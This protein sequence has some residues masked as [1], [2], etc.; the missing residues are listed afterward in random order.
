MPIPVTVSDWQRT[1]D[2]LPSLMGNRLCT[3]AV[4]H[5]PKFVALGNIDRCF[6]ACVL[7]LNHRA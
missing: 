7:E 5:L 1:L 4:G 6:S 2:S 3:H